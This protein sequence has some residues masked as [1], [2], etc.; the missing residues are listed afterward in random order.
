MQQ[1][2]HTCYLFLNREHN[3]S[4]SSH[5]QQNEC[6]NYSSSN[7]SSSSSELSVSIHGDT[8]GW[9]DNEYNP[10]GEEAIAR[11]KKEKMLSSRSSTATSD[12][13]DNNG[14][15][16]SK[17]NVEDESKSDNDDSSDDDKSFHSYDIINLKNHNDSD[18]DD[19][20]NFGNNSSGAGNINMVSFL[21]S[22]INYIFFIL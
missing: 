3:L 7:R 10:F 17:S 20:S 13:V 16:E 14:Y 2:L 6:K 19:N 8:P 18:D 12:R 1:N 4:E 21:Y 22:I 11:R 5:S 15:D 9:S